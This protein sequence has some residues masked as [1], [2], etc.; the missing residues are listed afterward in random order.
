MLVALAVV[1]D[2]LCKHHYFDGMSFS[3]QLVVVYMCRFHPLQEF[4]EGKRS[5]RRR[6]AGHNR[7]R[8][9]TQPDAAAAQA[10][11]VAEEERLS[12]GGSGLIGS[13]LNILSHLM[14]KTSQI[15]IG[16]FFFLSFVIFLN[17]F[18]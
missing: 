16:Q 5:C 3:T 18:K 15:T 1:G 13:L 2:C 8:R 7:R 12:K 4:D 14:G 6:L 9:K 10:L 11:L 17:V